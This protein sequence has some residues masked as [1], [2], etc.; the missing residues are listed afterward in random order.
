LSDDIYLNLSV[1]DNYKDIKLNDENGNQFLCESFTVSQIKVTRNDRYIDFVKDIPIK[2]TL[3]FTGVSP[4][5]KR[6]IL[7]DI[8]LK[9]SYSDYNSFITRFQLKDF[10]ILK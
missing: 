10:P 8:I 6:I 7:L 5:I 2:V 9:K 4:E 1:N 3:T